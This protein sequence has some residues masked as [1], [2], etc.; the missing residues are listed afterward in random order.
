[1]R[2]I[3]AGLF[4]SLDGVIQ[5][6]GGPNEDES[7]GF[8]FGGWVV[9]HFSETTGTFIDEIFSGEFDLLL[10][11]RTYDIFAGHW[12]KITGD[13]FAD[14]FNAAAKYVLTSLSEPLAWQNSHRLEDLA[15]VKRLKETEGPRLIVQ[16]SS[17]IY[18]GLIENGLIDRLFLLTFPIIL[19]SGKRALPGAMPA[20]F[21]LV[22]HRVSDSGVIIA[23]YEPSGAVETG[24]F[25]LQ[26]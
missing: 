25:A 23:V 14:K 4:Q 1:M 26:D 15:A 17:T 22:D 6:P 18:P 5:A 3:V 21:R 12:P 7:G 2:E 24:S 13:P 10:G 9:P 19:G 8:A 16:G 20:A 11:R